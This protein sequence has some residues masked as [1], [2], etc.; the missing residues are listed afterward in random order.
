MRRE[1]ARALGSLGGSALA[2]FGGVA[3]GM[4][5][6]TAQRVFRT[7]GPVGAPTRVMHDGISAVAYGAVD[8]GLRNLPRVA[9]T[10]IARAVPAHAERMA[11]SPV[12]GMALAALNGFWG[13]AIARDAA[14][15]AL[16]LSI[17]RRGREVECDSPGLAAAYPDA[18][19]K[20]AVF[21]HGLCEDEQ[22]W[23]I[24]GR[25]SY[26]A[27]LHEELGYTPVYVRYNTGLH[28][29]DNGR[30][31]AEVL[32]HVAGAWPTEVEEIVLVGHSMGGLVARSACH[33]GEK[34]G[35]AWV[36]PVRHVFCLGTPHLGAPL[37]RAANRAGH[38]LGRLGVTRP[39]ADVLNARSA[40]I[41]DLRYG[42]CIEEDW[43]DC[44]PDAYLGDRC[45]EVPFLP[46]ATYYFIGATLSRNPDSRVGD[47]LVQ[48]VSAS[49]NGPKRRIP[50]EVDNG[51]HLAGL[52]H[53]QLL[54]HPDVYAV[55]REWLVRERRG[56][57]LDQ[58]R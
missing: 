38:M 2:Q 35:R 5:V 55:M 45:N 25:R 37:E 54:N 4:H 21:V 44:D 39:F 18:T 9:G 24:T 15:V 31:L 14:D 30:R 34:D 26:G 11:D 16:E 20:L 49:G 43:C 47:L 40:G 33:Y 52:N 53:F 13:D 6:A 46:A 17:R 19:P 58:P 57:L 3:K 51:R 29:S 22:A 1:E 42:S 41:K 36:E 48:Y 12:G 10:A 27:R 56:K 28:I 23:S 50:F 7:L 32:H 8:K